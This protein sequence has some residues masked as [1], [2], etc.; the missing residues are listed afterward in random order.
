MDKHDR[1]KVHLFSVEN[2]ASCAQVC[3]QASARNFFHKL[4]F[5][6]FPHPFNSINHAAC[7]SFLSRV[8]RCAPPH[9]TITM[10][11]LLD[12]LTEVLH[13]I[14]RRTDADH[15]VMFVDNDTKGTR[16]SAFMTYSPRNDSMHGFHLTL[17]LQ[18]PSSERSIGFRACEGLEYHA[19]RLGGRAH[20]TPRHSFSSRVPA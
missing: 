12:R 7:S 5:V 15:T 1:S 17:N 2:T 3:R 13:D 11:G 6:L 18:P 8:R 14:I 16:K 20:Q 4:S 19:I 10:T 9:T